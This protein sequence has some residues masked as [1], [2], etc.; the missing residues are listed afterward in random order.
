MGL[1]NF[2]IVDVR[3]EPRGLLSGGYICRMCVFVSLLIIQIVVLWLVNASTIFLFGE[4]SPRPSCLTKV[5]TTLYIELGFSWR[6]FEVRQ[7]LSLRVWF[8]LAEDFQVL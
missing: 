6:S 5:A 2:T 7:V 3:R 4:V 1:W 8:G